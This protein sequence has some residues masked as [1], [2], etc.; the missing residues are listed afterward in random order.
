MKIVVIGTRGI[1]DIPGGVESH[2]Q[3]IY[4]RIVKMGH[5]V[6]VVC[7]SSYIP[8]DHPLSFNGVNLK[9]IFSPKLKSLEAIFH[10]LLAVFWAKFHGADILHVHAIGPALTIPLAR[11][12]GMKVVMTNHG[13]DYER[14][15]GILLP[16][17]L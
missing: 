15:N 17:M 13:P 1:P 10:S 4:P 6:T 16:L 14:Q 2:C 11:L 9:K 12:L 3:E 5:S 8:I 7:R